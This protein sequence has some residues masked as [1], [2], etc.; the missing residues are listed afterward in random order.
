[1]TDENRAPPPAEEISEDAAFAP[2]WSRKDDPPDD[3]ET[4]SAFDERAFRER[5]DAADREHAKADAE[6]PLIS[7]ENIAFDTERGGYLVKGLLPD[8]GLAVIWGPPK[9]G[10]SF[11]ATDIGLHIALDW[12]YRGR[13]VQQATVVYIALEG[14][15]GFPARIQAFKQHHGVQS[16]PFHLITKPLDLVRKAD[17][18]IKSIE[19]QLGAVKPGVVFLDTL[20]RSLV[21]SESKDEDMAAY[22][23][24]AGK[25]EEKFG[26]LVVIVHHCGIAGDRPRG[27][28][29]LTGA[30][31]VQLAVKKVGDRQVMVTVELAK[32][33]PEGTEI[34]S[35]LEP[36]DLGTDP[37]GDRITS[38]VVLPADPANV[39]PAE[40]R[41]SKNQRTLFAILHSAGASGLTVDQW[42]SEARQQGIGVSRKADLYDIRS[43]LH[44]KRLVREY[45]GRWYVNHQ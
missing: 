21:G 37:D 28:T 19:D 38:L 31:E 43:S 25:I 9:C 32:D 40:P 8:S 44:S 35:K 27:H 15:H 33:M 30:V 13:W 6:F 41:L 2:T 17:V 18:L 3:T 14:R 7:F 12:E 26:C 39:K 45:S 29:S 24:A 22:I 16:A 34:F 10:K 23:A 42:N 1:M 4:E 5:C 36:V 11:W 20:N